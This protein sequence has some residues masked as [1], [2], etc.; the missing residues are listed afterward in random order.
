MEN[1]KDILSRAYLVYVLMCVFAVAILYRIFV[2]QFEE[3]DEWRRK[4]EA[5]TTKVF[6]IEAVR[7]NIFDVNGNLL[8]T[9]LPYYEVGVDINAPS[10]DNKLFKANRQILL[11]FKQRLRIRFSRSYKYERC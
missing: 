3:G 11:S 4:A 9:S 10:I 1:K 8:A 7:G 5:F 2:I 6:E